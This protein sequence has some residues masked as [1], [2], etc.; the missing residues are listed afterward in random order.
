MRNRGIIPAYAG[1]TDGRARLENAPKDH[2][3]IRGE[4][5]EIRSEY[6]IIVPDHPRIRGEHGVRGYQ[7]VIDRGSSPHTRGARLPLG[8]PA[9]AAGI[10]PAY[11]GSTS[12]HFFLFWSYSDH[13]RIR[14]EHHL[15]QDGLL[16]GAGSSPHTRGARKNQSKGEAQCRIIPAYAGSTRSTLRW[17]GMWSDH[18]RIRGEHERRIGAPVGPVG[19]SPHTRGAR[20]NDIFRMKNEGIIPAYAGSTDPGAAAQK[21]QRDH[22]R[23]RG[24]HAVLS[25]PQTAGVGSSP[26][27]RGA[28]MK[29]Y[30]GSKW[31]DIIPAYAGSTRRAGSGWG[32]AS[33]HPRIRGE[34]RAG[35]A[36]VAALA[37][38]SPHTRGALRRRR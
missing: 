22:P 2:P 26:H 21:V 10:I 38:S 20:I 18:P 14:G 12:T 35:A 31:I 8:A 33:D 9:W 36:L 37:G 34:H 4:H 27:T 1:S 29:I 23:I 15:R 17:S 3:R 30:E 13:P 25:C 7:R 32:K 19:S 24:E 11:A 6:S 28:R 5:I 16:F